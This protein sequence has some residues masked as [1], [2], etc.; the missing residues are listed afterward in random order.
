M[1]AVN[2]AWGVLGNPV[3]RQRYDLKLSF[4]DRETIGSPLGS[5]TGAAQGPP[6]ERRMPAQVLTPTGD[7]SRFPWKFLTTMGVLAIAVV[8]IG[9]LLDDDRQPAAPDNFLVQGDCVAIAAG[10]Q[11]IT[12]VA[13]SG[14]H[15]GTVGQVMNFGAVCPTGTEKFPDPMGRGEA[16]V[17]RVS[18]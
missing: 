2:E 15:D 11:A 13:C 17:I 1:A 6:V 8:L 7:F 9:S 16:C 4:V 3:R 5:S 10:S 14:A 12:E 18:S